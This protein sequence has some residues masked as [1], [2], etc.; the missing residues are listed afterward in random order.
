M[1]EATHTPGPWKPGT[2]NDGCWT[3]FGPDHDPGTGTTSQPVATMIGDNK[4]ANA[5][6]IAAAPA[7]LAAIKSFQATVEENRKYWEANGSPL[8]TKE[9][10]LAVCL[11]TRSGDLIDKAIAQAEGGEV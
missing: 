10:G 3:V 1:S 7:M 9:H 4:A 11:N 2:W 5:R 6:L 8:D